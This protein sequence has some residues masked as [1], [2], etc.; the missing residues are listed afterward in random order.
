[1]VSEPTADAP[2]AAPPPDRRNFLSAV[3]A[4]VAGGVVAVTPLLAGIAFF[5]DPLLRKR[6]TMQGATAD[7]FLPVAMLTELPDDGTPLRF[8]LSA[9]QIDAWN[10]FKDQTIGTVYLRKIEGQVIAFNDTCPHLGCKVDFKPADRIFYCPCHAS[11]FSLDGEKTNQIPPRNMDRLETR[12]DEENRI[13][14]RYENFQRG[15]AEKKV[16]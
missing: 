3:A 5:L 10:L 4:V 15:I 1:M 13:W 6:P 12:V 7:G 14:V 16:V 2:H 9:D 8:A 11:A